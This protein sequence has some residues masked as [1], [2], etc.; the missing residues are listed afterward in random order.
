MK[1][2]D[3]GVDI[4]RGD[5]VV[6]RIKKHVRTT[7]NDNVLTDIGSFGGLYALTG[8]KNPVLVAGTDGVGTKLKIAFLSDTH[9]TVGIDLV[10]MSV[11]DVLVQGARPLFFLDYVAS[12]RLKPEVIETIV[13]GI[14]EGC[15]QSEC[16]LLGG[17]TAEMP[18]FYA[19]NEYD[20][21]GFAVGACERD[22]VITGEKTKIGDVV[23]GIPSTGV[24]SNG[25]SLARKALIDEKNPDK[26]VLKTL[27]TPTKIYV[28]SVL[29]VLEKADV[30]AMVHITG[31]GFYDNIPRILNADQDVYIK[32]GTWEILPVFKA[33][34]EKGPVEE[35][36]MFRTFN[37][38]IGY[39][40]IVDPADADTVVSVLK[41]HGENASIIGE[42]RKGNQ[43]VVIE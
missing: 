18:G 6:R 32:K 39:M 43:K 5:E 24:H 17:E 42:V 4:D 28:K 8:Y 34:M 7:F 40:I 41:Q 9:D 29:A 37:M 25:Y 2:S 26:E 10:A 1:Y 12:G 20:L 3:A 33:I 11:N 38:G 23:I 13:A 19:E 30:H 14:A 15:R 21:A 36:E 22:K 35:R 27:L 31:G 16:A